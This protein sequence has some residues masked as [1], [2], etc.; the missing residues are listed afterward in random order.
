MPADSANSVHRRFGIPPNLTSVGKLSDCRTRRSPHPALHLRCEAIKCGAFNH[1]ATLAGSWMSLATESVSTIPPGAV[2]QLGEH[3]L[4]KPG[5][6]GSSPLGST[7]SIL[8][9]G[10]LTAARLGCDCS[11]LLDASRLGY[12]RKTGA[13]HR[14]AKAR[15]SD[16]TDGSDHHCP[17]HCADCRWF[18]YG[19]ARPARRRESSELLSQVRMLCDWPSTLELCRHLIGQSLNVEDR[20]SLSALRRVKSSPGPPRPGF[21]AHVPFE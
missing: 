14:S 15:T 6:R 3:R 1:P 11:L 10:E 18:L 9:S 4:C 19:S 8:S 5:V 2:A 12:I 13:S 7:F 21:A 20:R 17:S 16:H